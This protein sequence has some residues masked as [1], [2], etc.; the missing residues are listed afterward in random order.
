MQTACSS[1]RQGMTPGF[2]GAILAECPDDGLGRPVDDDGQ[3]SR[4]PVGNAQALLP[5]LK[6]PHIET[7]T[8]SHSAWPCHGLRLDSDTRASTGDRFTTDR[9]NCPN[10]AAQCGESTTSLTKAFRSTGM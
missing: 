4:H 3:Y 5:L 1:R 2:A 8:I 7:E 10:Q 6:S 9:T